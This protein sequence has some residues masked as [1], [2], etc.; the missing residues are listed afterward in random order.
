MHELSPSIAPSTGE[1]TGNN[2]HSDNRAGQVFVGPVKSYE[3]F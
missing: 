3:K 2:S 1:R